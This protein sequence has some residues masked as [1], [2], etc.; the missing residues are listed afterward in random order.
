MNIRKPKGQSRQWQHQAHKTQYE[1]KQN[2]NK[3]TTQKTQKMNSTKKTG[4]E[5]N[6]FFN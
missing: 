6:I 4:G 1:D 3:N 2:T 5:K